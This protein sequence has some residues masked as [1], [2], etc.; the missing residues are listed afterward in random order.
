MKRTLLVAVVLTLS[1]LPL[2]ASAQSLPDVWDP[3]SIKG[4]LVTCQGNPENFDS[5]GNM[6]PNPYACTNLCD[7]IFTVETD[8]YVGIA[9]VIWIIL[10]IMLSVAGIMYMMG[11]ANPNLLTSAKSALKGAVVGAII[12]LC[13]YL[14]ISTF[15]TFLNISQIG[16]FNG[17]ST[18][19]SNGIPMPLAP[20][21]PT[22]L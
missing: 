17:N 3:A 5:A 14:L 22:G 16:G 8:I 1:F 11:G 6:T 13:A 18:C 9:F 7:L 19:N 4:P 15:V 21:Q 2:L 12:V 10:P 20:Q